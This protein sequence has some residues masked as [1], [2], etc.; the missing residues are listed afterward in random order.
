MAT[1]DG[2]M[3]GP[4]GRR[5]RPPSS[6]GSMRT[7]SSSSDII[8]LGVGEEEEPAAAAAAAATFPA[9]SPQFTLEKAASALE[10]N[11]S[12][13][14]RPGSPETLV[15]MET[16]MTRPAGGVVIDTRMASAEEEEE[17]E[18]EDG[19]L[20][21]SPEPPEPPELEEM[22][23]TEGSGQAGR[24][25]KEQNLAHIFRSIQDLLSK[26]SDQELLK[27]KGCFSWRG[28]EMNQQQLMVDDLLDFVDKM[29]EVLGPGRSLVR[30]ISCLEAIQMEEE[31][32]ELRSR[33]SR[34]LIRFNLQQ[35][36]SRT[37][38][39]LHEG[40]PRAGRQSLLDKVYVPPLISASVPPPG[41]PQQ[42]VQSVNHLFQL[43]G[44]HGRPVRTVLT[45]GIPGVGLSVAVAK[46]CLDW[47]EQRANQDLQFVV[48]LSFRD[49]WYLRSKKAPSHMM[50]LVEVMEYYHPECK[51]MRYLDEDD[52]R[53]LVV[54]DSF[55]CY[56]AAL[57]WQAPVIVD[58]CCPAPLDHLIVNIIR[59]NML[60]GALIWILGRQ[61][62]VSQIPSEF[63][64]VV[65][66]LQGFSD[67]AR[68]VFLTQRF[69]D[70]QFAAQVVEHHKR[71]PL[72]AALARQPFV[73]WMVAVELER[74]LPLL[75]YRLLPPR[76]T[77]FYVSIFI[78]QTNRRLEY[79]GG[80]ENTRSPQSW[81]AEVQQ[82][83]L[84]M[85]Q[86]A[87]KMLERRSSEFSEA[88][89]AEFGLELQEVT[90]FSGLC[91]ELLSSATASR[92]RVFCFQHYTLQEFMA[93]LYVLTMFHCS[94]RNVLDSG[95]SSKFSRMLPVL[96]HQSR[97]AADLLRCALDRTLAASPGH[98][99]LLLRFL[100]GLLSPDCHQSQL[101]GFLFPR[102]APS[103]AGLQ[104]ARRLLE[105]AVST[106][107]TRDREQLENLKECLRE[108]VLEEL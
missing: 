61:A 22:V 41:S 108:M 30:T 69:S 90:V 35:H 47:A 16:E 77:P 28:S 8:E 9:V 74:C 103:I 56:Q 52:C 17:Y 3:S 50:S 53:L 98:Y 34:A 62:A 14:R 94:S 102:H 75:E 4:P 81:P 95:S 105:G 45:S 1:A 31:A 78:V 13:G 79:Y 58:S 87:F 59:G 24:L 10:E 19:L 91:T 42:E 106:P 57:D 6:Y 71:Q 100:C 64:D 33:C 43:H 49:L 85:G 21:N 11:R 72:L 55:D 73:C 80:A 46:F 39:V 20:T 89:L 44:A 27:F 29:L 101:S 54:M 97:T 76:L 104:E 67:Q 66:E 38:R 88:D 15:T 83:L 25:H 60:C 5:V 82:Q 26:L 18:D 84:K 93:A 23:Q 68:D 107:Q 92:G 7:D 48:T 40:V 96:R 12:Q 86:M 63:I 32:A 37:F 70:P 99:N 2:G 51:D 65:T 36:L